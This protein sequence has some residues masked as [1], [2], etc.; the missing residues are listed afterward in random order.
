MS[1]VWGCLGAY[2]EDKIKKF[3]AYSSINQMGFLL[4]G[5]AGAA[6]ADIRATLIYL[7]IYIIMN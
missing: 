7:L 1:M 5:V 3:I 4:I 2:S 6:F